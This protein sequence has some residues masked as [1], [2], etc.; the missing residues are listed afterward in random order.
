LLNFFSFFQTN[1]QKK[2]I[3][4][5]LPVPKYKGNL[6]D[7][8]LRSRFQAHLVSLPAYDDYVKYLTTAY[9]NVDP[10]IIKNLCNFGFSFYTN[11]MASLN[12]PDFPVENIDKLVRILDKCQNNQ[13][14]LANLINKIYPHTFIL[15]DEPTNRKFYFELLHKFNLSSGDSSST[16]S[17]NKIE[18][19]MVSFEQQSDSQIKTLKFK[20][21]DKKIM[22]IDM[23]CASKNQ[24]NN[25][26]SAFVM[27]DYHASQLV[28]MMLNHSSGHDFCLIGAQGSGK[29]EL[30]KQFS[31]MLNYPQI[32]TT[33]LYKDMN[34]RDLLQQRITL[35]NGDTVWRNSTL[36]EAAL[37][38][39]LAVLDG[40][41]R[42]KD[43]TI[44]SLRRLIQD[45]DVE[46]LDGTKLLAHDKYDALI[47]EMK[48]NNQT[49]TEGK[50][51]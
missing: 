21:S 22:S 17:S 46:L 8:P 6:L 5:G 27:N 16:G 15:K 51:Q 11:E 33:Y 34:A 39:D 31:R 28:D 35:N 32:K 4:I 36:V 25:E 13:L 23:V 19:K 14:S 38:G 24:G 20:S 45:R 7:P 30:I 50:I 12:L 47:E 37:N 49:L 40:I 42:L 1:T 18:F 44:M 48:K 10:E 2:V 41:H 43:D 3:A 26:E 9:K 29:T